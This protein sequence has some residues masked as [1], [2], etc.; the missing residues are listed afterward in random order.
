FASVSRRLWSALVVAAWGASAAVGAGCGYRFVPKG[1]GLPAGVA[2]LCA[3]VFVNETPEPALETVFTRF[4]RQELTRVGRLSS[5]TACDARV[6]GAVLVVGNSPTIAGNYYRL[7]AVARLRL[8]KGGQLLREVAIGGSEDYLLGSGDIL[9][10]E[11]N[12]QAALDRLAETLMRDGY[13][14][15]ASTW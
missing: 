10:G 15:L 9:E 5:G 7:S 3:P 2:T 13:D 11:A 8:M 4:L 6:E 12:R 14:R 1:S